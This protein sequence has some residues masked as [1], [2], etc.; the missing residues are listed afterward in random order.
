MQETKPPAMQATHL[1][2]YTLPGNWEPV[3]VVDAAEA[4]E[5]A[6]GE[7]PRGWINGYHSAILMA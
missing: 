4:T 1:L 7:E 3:H 2:L 6:D 5:G